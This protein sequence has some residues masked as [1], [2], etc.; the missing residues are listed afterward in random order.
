M[1]DRV[2]GKVA[3][4]TGA[5]SGIGRACAIR[6]AEEGAHVVVTSRTEA[7]LEETYAGVRE[8]S[9]VAP[10]A[11][12]LDV[13][14][15]AQVRQVVQATAE[16][17]DHIDVLSHNA[18]V[19][20]PHAPSV[21]N[22]TD[23]DWHTVMAVNLTGTFHVSRAV[24]PHMRWGGSI[25]HMASMNSYVAWPD[26]ATY[27]ASKGGQ[28]QFSRALSLETAPLG[29]RVNAVCP[30]IIDTPLTRAFIDVADDPE[31]V[32]REYEAVS[33]LGRMGQAREV[34]NVVLFLAS[35]ESSFVT[36]SGLVVDGGSTVA[37]T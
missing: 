25:I 10:M 24:I 22:T 34:A 29:I 31:A 2:A 36:G 33:P 21:V 7:H 37:P 27:S 3:L 5:G 11:M 19:E 35:D 26:N 1:G 23:Q 18:G 4:V 8:R 16:R 30:G 15:A 32:V 12:V 6:L 13:T 28:L 20:L 17:F 9:R 14:D